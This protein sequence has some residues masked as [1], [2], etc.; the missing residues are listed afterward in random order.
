MEKLHLF[1]LYFNHLS[2]NVIVI[3]LVF[4]PQSL[5][6][7]L[8]FPIILSYFVCYPAGKSPHFK[9]HHS[10]IKP[11]RTGFIVQLE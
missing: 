11:D 7:F 2:Q 1:S 6:C 8:E 9:S 5:N 3:F 10:S 4:A